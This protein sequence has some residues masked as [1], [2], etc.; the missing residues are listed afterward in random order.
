MKIFNNLIVGG[1]CVLSID[2]SA[3]NM[4]DLFDS[5]SQGATGA[6]D[7]SNGKYF[8]GGSFTG[9]VKQADVDFLRF[10]P[11]SVGGGCSGIDI[12][13]G[14]F[15][16][17]SGDE[18]VQV[19]RGVAQGAAPYFFNIALNS[20]CP[21]CAAVS[22]DISNTIEKMN[23]FGKNA[24]EASWGALDETTGFSNAIG[25]MANSVGLGKDAYK[26]NIGS[27]FDGLMSEDDGSKK[28]SDS[29]RQE[30]IDQNLVAL[31]ISSSYTNFTLPNFGYNDTRS[32]VEFIQS[33]FGTV[34]HKAIV[35]GACT[36]SEAAGKDCVE[37][38]PI[39]P[40]LSLDTLLFGI[41]PGS[42]EGSKFRECG[43]GTN[44]VQ[45]CL[46]IRPESN[47]PGNFEGLYEKY[48]K[49]MLGDA[50]GATQDGVIGK[51]R[52]KENLTA[53]QEKLLNMADY[54]FLK[55]AK[56]VR[57]QAGNDVADMVILKMAHEQIEDVSLDILYKMRQTAVM[58][59]NYYDGKLVDAAYMNKLAESFRLAID[60]LRTK[61]ESDIKGRMN[62]SSAI[63]TYMQLNPV[64]KSG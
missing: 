9:R 39:N 44:Y 28:V 37:S 40:A 64:P 8:Y 20:I 31:A 22:K 21:A 10:S 50:A 56:D 45:A 6:Y 24:C 48:K 23:K 11:P 63:G 27:W 58:E 53:E 1:L 7:T 41:Q 57:G 61:V 14:S 3:T 13:A 16:M 15:G 33:V 47:L 32:T 25:D 30:I 2:A 34:I 19:A 17:V 26:G 59:S 36:A 18:L 46:D 29:T 60:N 12:F 42:T 4:Q 38:T 5:Y 62:V 35:S 52:R 43:T 55:I 49:I 54:N 51:Y